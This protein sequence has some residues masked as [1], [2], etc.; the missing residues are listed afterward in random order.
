[1]FAAYQA[2]T[3]VVDFVREA[4]P[5]AIPVIAAGGIWDRADIDLAI[6]A[7]AS[8]VQLGTRF[9]TT[10]ECDAADAYKAFHLQARAEDVVLVPSPVGMPGRALKNAFTTEIL[11]R[12]LKRK[13]A[14]VNCLHRCKY[15]DVGETYCILEALHRAAMGDVE[16]GLVFSGANAGQSDRLTS[17]ADLMTK[18]VQ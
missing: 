18:L 9:I 5:Q 10:E 15:R 13:T 16:Q 6:T 14:C 2:V 1:V 12:N 7:G 4:L 11:S 17:V 3:Q 8:G